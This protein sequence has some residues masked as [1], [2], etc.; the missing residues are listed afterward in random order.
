[1]G[2]VK[3]CIQPGQNQPIRYADLNEVKEYGG[4]PE[5]KPEFACAIPDLAADIT[6]DDVRAAF[7]NAKLVYIPEDRLKPEEAGKTE[8][9]EEAKEEEAEAD[10][11]EAK[12]EKTEE[13]NGN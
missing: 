1:M 9:A 5:Y 12:E 4:D 3:H 13:T 10:G 8:E 6:E 11:A 2:T 7:P